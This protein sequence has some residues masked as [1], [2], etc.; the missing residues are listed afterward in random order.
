MTFITPITRKF[1]IF[2]VFKAK[3]CDLGQIFGFLQ[4][5]IFVDLDLITP[6]TPK[7]R[8]GNDFYNTK[9]SKIY[10]IRPITSK[11]DWSYN[12]LLLQFLTINVFKML[13]TR[14]ILRMKAIEATHAKMQN[15]HIQ[16]FV[17]QSLLPAKFL[18]YCLS[19]Q[20]AP[21]LV[22]YEKLFIK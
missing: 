12:H 6:I 8:G 14:R 11:S 2:Y 10:E 21:T 17:S 20:S 16:K 9:H 22:I 5:V 7:F 13:V 4:K 3:N 18:F 15:F 19:F 1:G